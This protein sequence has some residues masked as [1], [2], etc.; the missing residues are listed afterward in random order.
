MSRQIRT[1]LGNADPA[2][3]YPVG[4]GDVEALMRRGDGDITDYDDV[5]R[6][7]RR[8][9]WP[10]AVSLAAAALVVVLV[11]VV[12]LR[13]AP[14]APGSPG[15]S[16]VPDTGGNPAACLRPI[17]AGLQPTA[18]DGHSGRYEYIHTTRRSGYQ[19]EIP[20]GHGALA[21]VTYQVND[22]SWLA[23]DGS[24]RTATTPGAPIF[25]DQV[26][27]D[28]FTHHPSLLPFADGT[29]TRNLRPT[30]TIT[31]MPAADPAAMAQA[32]YQ[33]RENGP[34]YALVGVAD[35]GRILDAAHRSA[36]LRFLADLDGVTCRGSVTDD[37]GRTGVLISADGG[38]G[39]NQPSPGDQSR[40]YLLLDPHTG[41]V[42]ASGG[43]NTN[44]PIIWWLRYDQRSYT[45][46]L[47]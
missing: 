1:L 14:A 2:R 30:G 39:D 8:S 10:A 47:G 19:T 26:S 23:A 22:S 34:A 17:I 9:S 43:G 35:F 27:R 12:A 4:T 29:D 32:L 16:V 31:A 5:V 42:L 15:P 7:Y 25:P 28:F 40:E 36:E 11:T 3:G 33:F 18:Y 37:A 44:G 41:E 24:G 45:N 13:P 38:P 21:T 20:G 46:T 6:R